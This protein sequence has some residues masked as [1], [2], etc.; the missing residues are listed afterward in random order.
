MRKVSE[1]TNIPFPFDSPTCCT[2]FIG[3]DGSFHQVYKNK[4][5]EYY[6]S[7]KEGNGNLLIVWPGQ[8]RSDA[9]LVDDI[10]QY[11][12]A[13]GFVVDSVE[14]EDNE[15]EDSESVEVKSDLDDFI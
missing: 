11:G 13:K 9:F 5:L 10:D 15:S 12:R 6:T 4:E 14:D 8:Y 7:V 3:N 1:V 2:L